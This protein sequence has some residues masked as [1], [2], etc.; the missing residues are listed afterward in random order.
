MVRPALWAFALLCLLAAG[1]GA[2]DYTSLGFPDGHLTAFERETRGWRL[3]AILTELVLAGFAVIAACGWIGRPALALWLGMAAGL[4]ILLP[5]VA[6]PRC[7]AIGSCAG[8][9]E[10]L[11]GHPPD[12]GIGG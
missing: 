9:Y 12:H 6:L 2:L 1:F 7:P 5:A 10:I 3:A 11:T 8:L 4:L